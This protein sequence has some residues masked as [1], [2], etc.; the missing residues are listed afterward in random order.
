MNLKQRATLG[1]IITG[2]YA[3][4]GAIIFLRHIPI[5]IGIEVIVGLTLLTGIVLGRLEEKWKRDNQM[6]GIVAER[7]MGR[8]SNASQPNPQAARGQQANAIHHANAT[9]LGNLLSSN[10]NVGI[11]GSSNLP[12]LRK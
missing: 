5:N 6:A 9:M 10:P 1:L 2:N 3:V 8:Q 4:D 11:A 7:L 12:G